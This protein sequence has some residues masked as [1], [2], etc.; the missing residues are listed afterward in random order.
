MEQKSVSY[1]H[2]YQ[3]QS[4]MEGVSQALFQ[5]ISWCLEFEDTE[6][7]VE[8]FLGETSQYR[9]VTLGS[10]WVPER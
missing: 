7:E 3:E 1:I 2:T 4:S 9:Q 8:R 5:S 6:R 10:V